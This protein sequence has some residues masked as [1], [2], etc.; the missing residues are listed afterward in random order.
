MLVSNLFSA[1]HVSEI[2]HAEIIEF[3][4][5]KD[6]IR[7]DS[8]Q[9]KGNNSQSNESFVRLISFLSLSYDWDNDGSDAPSLESVNMAA[10]LLRDHEELRTRSCVYP[11]RDGGILI[12]WDHIGWGYSLRV[13][14]DGNFEF[15]GV[16]FDGNHEKDHGPI[17]YS[18]YSVLVEHIEESFK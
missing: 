6:Q 9:L 14:N 1:T 4:H 11:T 18:D 13:L 17:A 8:T 3:N 15:L 5:Q 12:E 7:N 16:E 10:R 2:P